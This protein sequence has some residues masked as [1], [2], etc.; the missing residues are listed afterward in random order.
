MDEKLKYKKSTYHLYTFLVSK[1]IGALGSSVYTFGISMYILSMTGSSL[2]FAANLL[3]SIVPRTIISPIA[4][5]IG[6]KV[7]RKW[8]VLGGQAGVILTVST[9]L[10]YTWTVGLSLTA[11]Y[12]ATLFNSIF[13][14]FSSVAFSAS[15]SNLVDG[16]RIQKAMSFNQLSLSVSGIGGPI[17]GGMLF[18][19]ASMEVFLAIFIIAAIITLLLESTMNF[20]LYKKPVVASAQKETMLQ[21][22]KA[23][24]VYLKTKP[25]VRA[26]LWT[27]LWL[28]LFFTCLSVGI[29][30][31]LLTNLKFQPQLIGF[32]EA[33]AAIGMLITAIYLA[34]RSNLK[35]PLVVVKRSTL[36]M[37]ISVILV[38]VP[39]LFSWSNTVNFIYYLVLMFVAGGFGVTTNTP[40]GVIMQTSVDE[41]YKGRVFGIVEMMAMSM[42]P[43]GTLIYGVLY[44]MMPAQ[45]VL[46]VSGTI[47]IAIVLILLRG[48][49][50]RMAH[51]ELEDKRKLN[52]LEEVEG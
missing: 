6:D 52:M 18:G 3:F 33:A 2:S 45:Y 34:T 27:A 26:I 44:D 40:I 13:S 25:V 8:L 47:L 22:F 16:E 5:L 38:A 32:I 14:S 23:G 48:S 30:F 36:L 28:N 50:I 39:L 11:I 12:L 17:V 19:F 41:E 20:T 7:P 37:A 31:V 10:L 42:M 1:M 24:F 35:F 29:G 49:V 43:L 21:S 51:P 4:G 15:I 46:I 9:L